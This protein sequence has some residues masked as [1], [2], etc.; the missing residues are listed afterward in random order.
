VYRGIQ[1]LQISANKDLLHTHH[2]FAASLQ[3]MPCSSTHACH[4]LSRPPC[5]CPCPCPLSLRGEDQ[6]AQ[7]RSAPADDDCGFVIRT[8]REQ[9]Q[10]HNQLLK[11]ED[12][13]QCNKMMARVGGLRGTLALVAL[14]LAAVL[15]L[16]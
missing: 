13:P 1:P 3:A 11:L 5:P 12:L 9:P 6:S 8:V 4:W 7:Q 10:A 15:S 14:L 2:D 16:C